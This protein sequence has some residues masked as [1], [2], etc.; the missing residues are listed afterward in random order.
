MQNLLIEKFHS[1]LLAFAGAA[2]TLIL[3]SGSVTDPVNTPKM[4]ALGVLSSAALG[5]VVASNPRI[6]LAKYKLV[7][8]TVFL[9][10]AC[11]IFSS[12]MSD[13]PLTQILYGS[14][15]RNTGL[16]TYLFLAALLI[17]TLSLRLHQSFRTIAFGL[18]FA[19]IANLI[20]GLWVILFGDFI[21]WDNPYKSILGTFGNPN[22]IGAFLGI[23][24]STLVAITIDTKSSRNLRIFSL[25]VLPICAIEILNTN[26]IQGRVVAAL[27]SAIVLFLYFRSRFNN[28]FLL[29]YTILG[30]IGGLFALAGALQKG[31]LT[32]LIYKTSVSLRGQYWLAGWNTGESHPFTGV[33]MDSFGDWYRRM[34]DVHALELP[35]VNTVVNAAHNV[36]I[37]IF[38]FGG[39]PLFLSYLLIMS[40][41]AFSIIKVIKR[42][43]AFDLTFVILV[44]AWAGYQLQSI[45]S[46]NQIGLAIW[47]WLLTGTLIAYE[48]ATD[49]SDFLST[50]EFKNRDQKRRSGNRSLPAQI[51][52]FATFGAII[53][54]L[55]ALPPFSADV[56]W[57]SAVLTRTLPALQASMTVS[58]FNPPNSMK[59]MQNIQTLEQSNLPDLSHKYALEAVKWNPDSYD[60][61]KA[62]Y[63]LKNSTEQERMLALR[64]LK[65]LDPLNP[66]VTK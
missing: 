36:P 16:L 31:P 29:C 40:L 66:D 25:A 2:V 64:N 12:I 34:R 53:G 61:W 49:S 17:S 51:P 24:F 59:Y 8:I 58:Y 20:Y 4:L 52:L 7:M 23:I 45:I 28:I 46:I 39:W 11:M 14:Y 41:G 43:K 18:F 21:G 33:G 9:F 6:V 48:R 57:R 26:A 13:A 22:F 44:S 32:S 50:T 60:F 62:L 54:L 19:G 37:D 15:G 1:K 55:I 56:K 3:V 5:V 27:G 10:I 42:Q 63:F 35:G 47:G 38:A 30:T 65:R